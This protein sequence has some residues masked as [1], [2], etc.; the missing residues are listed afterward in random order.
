MLLL[1]AF[2]RFYSANIANALANALRSLRAKTDLLRRSSRVELVEH[3]FQ[4]EKS[5][6]KSIAKIHRKSWMESIAVSFGGGI[7][8][9]D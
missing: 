6:W 8:Q 2:L 5:R 7:V 4:T 9:L 1:C 3:T